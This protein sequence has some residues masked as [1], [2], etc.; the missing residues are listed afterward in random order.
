MAGTE[1]PSELQGGQAY[2]PPYIQTSYEEGADACRAC[3]VSEEEQRHW[4][5]G[6]DS[7]YRCRV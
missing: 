6:M 2:Q 7:N 1:A 4:G 3:K 5:D